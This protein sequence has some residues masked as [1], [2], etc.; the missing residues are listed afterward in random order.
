M[1]AWSRQIS[2]K[3]IRRISNSGFKHGQRVSWILFSKRKCCR[4]ALTL[5]HAECRITYSFYLTGVKK[6][7]SY[8]LNI[9]LL[10][11]RGGKISPGFTESESHPVR[12]LCSLT[13]LYR[14]HS[15][16]FWDWKL[17]LNPTR[18]RCSVIPA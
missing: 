3:T 8:P 15:F 9:A 4:H 18:C 10:S 5:S 6:S 11:V 12:Y 14:N 13:S 16:D 7:D 1:H 2:L 17:D